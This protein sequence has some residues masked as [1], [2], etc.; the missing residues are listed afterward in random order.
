MAFRLAISTAATD[1]SI[2]STI[3]DVSVLRNNTATLVTEAPTDDG[4]KITTPSEFETPRSLLAKI[5]AGILMNIETE[6][7]TFVLDVFT[8]GIGPD[9]TVN[10]AIYRPLLE[11]TSSDSGVFEG[12]IEYKMLNQ[13]VNR[14]R[15]HV[16]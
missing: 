2:G 7:T 11:E 9:G 12:T 13:I 6:S 3:T 10:N 15:G 16:R 8:F 14:Q 1:A 4:P 5:K